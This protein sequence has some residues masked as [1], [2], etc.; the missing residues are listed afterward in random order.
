MT[1]TK[2]ELLVRLRELKADREYLEVSKMTE[3][4]LF[5]RLRELKADRECLRRIFGGKAWRHPKYEAVFG[6]LS[7]LFE[8]GLSLCRERLAQI[9]TEMNER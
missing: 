4:E 2:E 3:A 6:P 5:V 9:S 7:P 8:P 1:V